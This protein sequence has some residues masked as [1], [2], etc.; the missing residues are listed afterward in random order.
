MDGTDDDSSAEEWAQVPTIQGL[1]VSTKGRVRTQRKGGAMS[2]PYRPN[3]DKNSGYRYVCTKRLGNLMLCTFRRSPL[4]TETA[5]HIAKYDGDWW[6]ERGD[7]RLSNLRWASKSEQIRN[8]RV[9]K[10]KRSGKPVLLRRPE[11]PEST[12]SLRFESANEAAKKLQLHSGAVS[13][14]A[15]RKR[16]K[17]HHH[18]WKITRAQPNETQDD[19]VDG[20]QVEAWREVH[21]RLRVSSFGRAQ[22]KN[23]LGDGWGPRF[24]PLPTDGNPYAK[25]DAELAHIIVYQTFHGHLEEGETV[26]HIDQNKRNNRA[27]N[28][29]AASASCQNYNR[30]VSSSGSELQSLPV[31]GRPTANTD[32]EWM[33]FAS[34]NEAARTLTVAQGM[35]FNQ[36]AISKVVLGKAS[37]TNGWTFRFA[38]PTV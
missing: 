16:G 14:C 31:Q 22:W 13:D 26:D 30:V 17:M 36:G 32:A 21:P 28:L 35:R 25:L 20:N 8:Q 12:P 29:R 24:L 7:D 37:S 1:H 4:P 34:Q 19:L 23:N 33:T 3:Q 6:R 27:D 18:G 11:W 15:N 5:D 2:L 10:P 9:H 38:Q